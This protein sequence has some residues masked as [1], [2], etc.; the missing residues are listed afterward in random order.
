MDGG[1]MMDGWMDGWIDMVCTYGFIFRPLLND[2]LTDGRTSNRRLCC[3]LYFFITQ[4]NYKI[5]ATYLVKTLGVFF[6]CGGGGGGGHF[7]QAA[8]IFL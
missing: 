1:W 5:S 8:E 6:V 2:R 7:F 4:V 3:P